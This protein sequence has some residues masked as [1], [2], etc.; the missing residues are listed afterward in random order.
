MS[1]GKSTTKGFVNNCREAPAQKHSALTAI[2]HFLN[3]M[4]NGK[5]M[6]Q[7]LQ[8]EINI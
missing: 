2:L 8:Y 5:Y 3:I 7:Q 4:V 1:V 6:Q